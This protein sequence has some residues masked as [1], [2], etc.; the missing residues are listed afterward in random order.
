M[1]TVFGLTTWLVLANLG[2]AQ[3]LKGEKALKQTLD[4]QKKTLEILKGIK[5]KDTALRAKATLTK[6]GEQELPAAR[7]LLMLTNE[8]RQE[9]EKKYQKEIDPI[10]KGVETELARIEKDRKSVV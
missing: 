3:E 4:V 5:D 9:L 1:R 6:L 8:E 2:Q 10:A 7:A